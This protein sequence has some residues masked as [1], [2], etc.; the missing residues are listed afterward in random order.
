MFNWNHKIILKTNT[1]NYVS[2]EVLLQF[3]DDD[4]LKLVAFF[5]KEALDHRKQLQNLQQ[6]IANYNKMF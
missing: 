3:N 4:I 2:A 5:F 1:S 6:E